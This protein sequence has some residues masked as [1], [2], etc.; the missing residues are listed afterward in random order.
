MR[1]LDVTQFMLRGDLWVGPY[2]CQGGAGSLVAGVGVS[3]LHQWN[4]D[5]G[6]S[7]LKPDGAGHG[8]KG[9]VTELRRRRW[10]ATVLGFGVS[11]SRRVVISG[12]CENHPHVNGLNTPE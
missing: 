10:V 9:I 6:S 1:P 5:K 8:V 3:G 12:E 11:Y 2:S 4:Q 7:L